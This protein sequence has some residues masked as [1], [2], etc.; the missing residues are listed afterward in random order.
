MFIPCYCTSNDGFATF[1]KAFFGSDGYATQKTAITQKYVGI[2]NE[3]AKV[4]AIIR[5]SSFICNNRF[6]YDAYASDQSKSLY[7]M[8]YDFL[9]SVPGGYDTAIHGADLLPTYYSKTMNRT[10]VEYFLMKRAGISQ[11]TA[12]VFMHEIAGLATDYQNYL[13][14]F[15][16]TG[17]PKGPLT[18]N[19]ATVKG[20]S[21]N[22]VMETAWTPNPFGADFNFPTVDTQVSQV[23]CDFWRKLTLSL[24]GN[25][26]QPSANEPELLLQDGTIKVDL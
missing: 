19:K 5:D 10:A 7:M 9:S 26:T 23:T 25:P 20:D 3:R 16:A 21:L 24:E 12:S 11:T 17:V 6:V 2:T 4:Q 14:S 15:A 22:N 18:W 1:L 8:Q 13:T